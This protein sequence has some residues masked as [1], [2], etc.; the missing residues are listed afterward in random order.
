MVLCS[1]HGS[2][3]TQ[4]TLHRH[5]AVVRRIQRPHCVQLATDF[6]AAGLAARKEEVPPPPD[7]SRPVDGLPLL[8]SY[9]CSQQLYGAK[10]T[11]RHAIE[12]HCRKAHGWRSGP[13]GQP[14]PPPTSPALPSP[15]AIPQTKPY[16]PVTPQTLW[17]ETFHICY[18][19]V[20]EARGDV[21]TLPPN[22]GQEV[23]VDVKARYAA[24]QDQQ[25]ARYQ[26]VEAMAHV[27]GLTPWLR[28][29]RYHSHLQ[30]LPLPKILISYQFLDHAEEPKLAAICQGV[31]RLLRK[32]IALLRDEQGKEE[33]QLS[34]LDAKLLNT[35]RGAEMSQDPTKPLQNRQSRDKYIATWQK[36]VC[37][38]HR[39]TYKDHFQRT[40]R[41]L[42][43]ID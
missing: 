15:K 29:T 43:T 11:N 1:H 13:K 34:Q 10:S 5:L 36:L 12:M 24:A 2:C 8:P 17:A 30:G 18:F 32:G 28:D 40:D 39:V 22:R 42:T 37:Y 9:Q 38:F 14:K 16:H 4:D 41:S 23:W 25:Q 6:C 21:T 3:H 27:S 26:V 20:Q 35:F 7:G 31:Q 19:V 33:R